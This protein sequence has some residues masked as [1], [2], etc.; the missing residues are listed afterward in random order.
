MTATSAPA[1]EI[2]RRYSVET[3]AGDDDGGGPVRRISRIVAS[4]SSGV[5]MRMLGGNV[6]I[7]AARHLRQQRERLV[8]AQ[9][10]RGSP[11]PLQG[12]GDR[13]GTGKATPSRGAG[14][15]A[16]KQ[17]GRS[18]HVYRPFAGG[19]VWI[20]RGAHG[21]LMGI[22]SGQTSASRSPE[23]GGGPR[24]VARRRTSGGDQTDGRARSR[25]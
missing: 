8:V 4:Q 23:F 21:E 2:S 18:V 10:V 25:P 11:P 12:G 24:N 5:P 13:S 6:F 19:G 22:D 17:N 14:S 3:P 9:E 16:T 15:F 20:D 1:E 7:A